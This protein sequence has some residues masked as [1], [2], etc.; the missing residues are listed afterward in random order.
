MSGDTISIAVQSYYNSHSSSTNNSSF[1]EVLNSLA[2]GLFDATNGAHGT[3]SNLTS[4]GSSV[5][6][7]VSSF[8]SSNESTSSGYPKAYLNWI[9]IDDQFRCD[10]AS[11]GAIAAA[12]VTY[13]SGTLNTVAPGSPLVMKK[14]GYLYIWVSNETENW[15]VYFDNLSVQ[16][17]Q[18][19]PAG[20]KSLLPVRTC[21]G[22]NQ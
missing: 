21:H 19:P 6:S 16:H 7:G 5:Y 10:S 20:G 8:L 13:P 14:S 3:V 11:S 18:G 9:F 22:R 15:D 12:S 4:S 2:N 17:K 1:T